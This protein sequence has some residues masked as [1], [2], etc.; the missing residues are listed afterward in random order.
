MLILA[1][2]YVNV[3]DVPTTKGDYVSAPVRLS[4]YTLQGDAALA[5]AEVR[6]GDAELADAEVREVRALRRDVDRAERTVRWMGHGW[7]G[8]FRAALRL[9]EFLFPSRRKGHCGGHTSPLDKDSCWD[10]GGDP[11]G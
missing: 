1:I 11:G 6:E 9:L 7:G 10:W 4:P 8:G 2:L 3:F 5:D